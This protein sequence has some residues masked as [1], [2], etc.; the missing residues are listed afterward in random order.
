MTSTGSVVDSPE[1]LQSSTSPSSMAAS[2]GQT[3][4][5]EIGAGED[6]MDLDESPGQKTED[7][8]DEDMEGMDMKARALTKLLQTSSVCV[9]LYF[10]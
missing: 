7:Q 2:P 1:N 6:K 5:A 3:M 9:M 8:D 4:K 10:A